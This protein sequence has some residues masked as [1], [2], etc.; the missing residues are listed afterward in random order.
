MSNEWLLTPEEMMQGAEIAAAPM[1]GK[2]SAIPINVDL[3]RQCQEPYHWDDG[4]PY[5]DTCGL[6]RASVKI[7]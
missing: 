7:P 5:C 3:E 1:R 4:V 2:C 6:F